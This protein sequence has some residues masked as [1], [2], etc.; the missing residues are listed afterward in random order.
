MIAKNLQHLNETISAVAR[1]CGR[2]REE[3]QVVAV[4]KRF[5]AEAI[6]A[7]CNAG[8]IHF[9][10]NYVQEL[11]IKAPLS[12]QGARFHFIGHLQSN[13]AKTVVELCDVVE[14]VD[15]EKLGRILNK[16]CLALDKTLDVLVQVNIG[17]DPNKS[18]IK[19]EEAANL[20]TTLNEL[21]H[22][23]VQGLMTIPP[24]HQS[25]EQNRA[26]FRELRRLRD[27]LAEK[28]LFRD[29]DRPELSMG[30]S[31]DFQLAIEEGATIIRV[32]TA[33]FGP[34]PL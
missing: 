13:K 16:H 23:R 28:G 19:K 6:E 25:A 1:Q 9:G 17:A 7:A 4:S 11:A 3:I 18:G 33:I 5:S 20:I 12:P 26:H 15:R 8:Q 29:T 21:S 10:E 22:I 14:S 30:M 24:I 2:K 34:R 32:G 27:A 31:G